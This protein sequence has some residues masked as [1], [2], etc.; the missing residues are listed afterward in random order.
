MIKNI[1]L[2]FLISYLGFFPFLITL[3][4]KFFFQYLNSNI[5]DDFI[6]IYS[7]VI[8][9][10]IGALHWNLSQHV[11]YKLV[12][13]GFM[14]S[15]ATVFIILM[16]FLSYEVIWIIIC[17]FLIQLF[18]DNFIYREKFERKVYFILRAPLSLSIILCLVIMKL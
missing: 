14:P 17:L 3:I 7:L 9:V 16:F 12:I 18:A 6:I 13:V 4:D 15:F 5:V 2:Q 10:F 11:P 1:N 8:F